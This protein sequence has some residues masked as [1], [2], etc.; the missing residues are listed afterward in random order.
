M[1]NLPPRRN[2]LQ[3]PEKVKRRCPSHTKW[4]GEHSCSVEGCS[5]LPIEVAHVRRGTNCGTGL[6]PSDKWTI[7][8][9]QEHHGEQHRVGEKTFSEEHFGGEWGMKE[10]AAEFARRSLHKAKLRDM[11]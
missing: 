4:V 9:C 2:A 3:R 6:K 11:P 7:S 10:L 5:G 1:P 8:L